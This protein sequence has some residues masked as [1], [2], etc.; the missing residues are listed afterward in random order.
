MV[1]L[2]AKTFRTAIACCLLC[3]LLCLLSSCGYG[4]DQIFGRDDTVGSRSLEGSDRGTV[5]GEQKALLAK[6]IPPG[7]AFSFIATSDLHFSQAR[8]PR[9]AALEGFARLA[10]ESGA[11]FALF[12][13]DYADRGLEEE[14]KLFL[15]FASTLKAGSSSHL[16]EG[17][18][19]PWFSVVGNHD[20][21][22][23]GWKYYKK[24]LGPSSDSFSAGSLRFYCID[25]GSG[26]VGETQLEDLGSAMSADPSPK[27]VLSHYPVHGAR[28]YAYFRLT[29]TRERAQLLSMF[30]SYGVKLLLC[31]HW[32]RAEE[33]DCGN[34]PEY[35]TGSLVDAKPDGLARAV[36][37]KVA[38][39]GSIASLDRYTF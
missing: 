19:L 38:S 34:F 21:Y 35:L 27:V 16:G 30:N 36:L 7:T 14:Y 22:N 3:A 18:A 29:N 28:T 10:A 15:S 12:G 8:G 5:I 13:G 9:A 25:T 31:G 6:A 1:R 33:A 2:R 23:S 32:H 37:V 11:D 24:Y 26:T 20:L 39:D 4:V 17:A